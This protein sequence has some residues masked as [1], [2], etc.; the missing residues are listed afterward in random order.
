MNNRIMNKIRR[1]RDIILYSLGIVMSLSLVLTGCAGSSPELSTGGQDL[2]TEAQTIDVFAMD[3]YMTLTAY[4]DEDHKALNAASDEISRIEKLVSAT[5]EN[6]EIFQINTEGKGSVSEDTAQMIQSALDVNEMTAGTFDI[7]V[8][9]L[10]EAWGFPDD[11]Y[12]VP[13]KKKINRLLKL[14]DSSKVKLDREKDLTA[15]TLEK[16][17]MK[18][19]LGGIAK[20]YTSDRIMQVFQEQGVSQ[21]VVSLGGNVQTIGRKPDGSLWKIGIEDPMDEGGYLGT[22]EVET[23]AVITSGNYQRYFEKDGKRYHHIIDPFTG[24]P[25]ETGLN[26]VTVVSESGTLADGLSTALFTMGPEKAIVFWRE[27]EEV[28][29]MIL[30]LEDGRILVSQGLADSFT[31]DHDWELLER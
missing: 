25:A 31:S 21:A 17:G 7:T 12:Q 19:D 20:G 5:D 9:P 16:K 30:C 24:Y 3:T 13:G 18:I 11:H 2:K 26:S 1:Y 15:V 27:H 28:F 4:G 10:V 14:V 29:D 23:A 6:S 8:Y 22:L